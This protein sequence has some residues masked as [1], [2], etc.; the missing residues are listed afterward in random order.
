[1]TGRARHGKSRPAESGEWFGRRCCG[2]GACYILSAS[3]SGWGG[4]GTP[5]CL[6]TVAGTW[7]AGRLTYKGDDTEEVLICFANSKKT[8]K[9]N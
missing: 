9:L 8:S 3:A 5:Y 2:P 4:S 7:Y 1:M 6:L